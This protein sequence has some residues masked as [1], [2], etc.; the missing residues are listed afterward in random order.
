MRDYQKLDFWQRSHKLVLRIYKYTGSFPKEE[1]FGIVSQIRRCAVSIPSNI[2]EGCGRNSIL[3]LKRFL[4]IASGSASELQYQLILSYDLSYLTE[5]IFKELN[6]EIILIRKMIFHY[7]NK[8][9]A[10]C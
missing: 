3:E 7:S 9:T 4:A 10:D 8:L 5:S 1:M 6:L 2:A